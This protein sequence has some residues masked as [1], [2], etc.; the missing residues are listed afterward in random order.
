MKS[1]LLHRF[2]RPAALLLALAALPARALLPE[3]DRVYLGTMTVNG[4][5]VTQSDTQFVV[6][7]NRGAPAGPEVESYRMGSDTNYHR[8][9]YGLRLTLEAITPIATSQVQYAQNLYLSLYSNNT[10]VAVLTNVVTERAQQRLDFGP[11]ADSDGDGVRDLEEYDIHH[12]DPF[13]P[14]TDGDG[15]TDGRELLATLSNALTNDTDHDLVNDYAEVMSQTDPNDSNSFPA[16]ISGNIVYSGGQTG[17]IWASAARSTNAANRVLVLDGA[18]D[19]LAWSGL[20]YSTAGQVTALTAEAWIRTTSSVPCVI[21]GFGSNAA[22]QLGLGFSSTVGRVAFTTVDATGLRHTSIGFLPVNDG[23]WHHVAATFDGATGAKR[24]YVD[25]F[26]DT[27]HTNAHAPGTGLFTGGSI[28]ARAGLAG[29]DSQAAVFDGAHGTNYFRGALDE[30]RL[31]AAA[32]SPAEIAAGMYAAI[33]GTESGLVSAISFDD[34]T[35]NDA[36]PAHIDGYLRGDAAIISNA[37][38]WARTASIPLPGA[39]TLTNVPTLKPYLI[40]AY[41]DSNNNRTQDYWEARGEYVE[42]PLTLAGNTNGIN[43]ALTDPDS[44]SDLLADYLELFVYHTN[45]FNPDTD[46][47]GLSDGLEV[48]TVGSDPLKPDTDGDGLSDGAEVLV[49]GTAPLLWDTDG[50]RFGDAWEI[51]A[52]TNPLLAGSHPLKP[53]AN[54]FDG[55]GRSDVAVDAPTPSWWFVLQSQT[56]TL[57]TQYWGTADSAGVPGDFDGDGKADIAVYRPLT[58]NWTILRSSDQTTVVQNWGWSAA[59]PV[60]A[61]Y[62]GDGIT[63]YAVFYPANGTWYVRRSTDGQ[64]WEQNWG[65]NATIPV[66]GDYDGD[67]R[68][69]LAVYHPAAGRW[70]IRRSSNGQLLQ[71]DWGWSAANPIPGDYDGDGTTDI[72]VIDPVAAVWYI[73]QSSTA[74]LRQQQFGWSETRPVMGDY[75]GDGLDDLVIYHQA[76]GNWYVLR[77]SAGLQ[78]LSFGWF[79]AIPINQP[80]HPAP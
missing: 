64:L 48:F 32:K 47:D 39:Y 28:P 6:R 78:T 50:D 11:P 56:L 67:G 66:P 17:L 71:L 54:D 62:D 9:F 53:R 65:W 46:G 75:D 51:R 57:R 3:P 33:S 69:D 58:G 4:R 34:G 21:A 79:A 55:D 7:V 77:S 31:W 61:D 36:S 70:Y 26:S 76:T 41:R 42:N 2:L 38:G 73:R 59:K 40:T 30:V 1:N 13:N 74:T 22:W 5:G 29:V 23:L 20:V 44:D 16:A 37:L 45:P 80:P 52:G 10:F 49:H 43:M 60:P 18:G 35:A 63:D 25:G 8:F 27:F 72:A 15:L 24:I 12:T 19:Y 68:A 14:D